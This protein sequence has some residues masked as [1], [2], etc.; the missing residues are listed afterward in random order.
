[1]PRSGPARPGPD[2]PLLNVCHADHPAQTTDALNSYPAA[3][4]PGAPTELGAATP[5]ARMLCGR[6]GELRM[7]H[8][9]STGLYRPPGAATALSFS[10]VGAAPPAVRAGRR[11]G[12]LRAPY[13]L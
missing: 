8:A 13:R 7:P 1:M 12:T 6:A 9:P 11:C 5:L 2:G 4:S 3:R 10:G